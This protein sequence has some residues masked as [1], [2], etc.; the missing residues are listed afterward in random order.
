MDLLLFL[1]W[2]SLLLA[3]T[4]LLWMLSLILARLV[5]E[6]GD[7]QRALDRKAVM[8]AFIEVMGG[9][10]G[11]TARLQPYQWRARLMAEALLELL[12]LVR[13]AERNRVIEALKSLN[14]DDRFRERVSRGS[15]AGRLAATEVLEAFPGDQTRHALNRL[16]RSARDPEL[17]IAAVRALIEIG[18]PPSIDTV[19]RN[20]EHHDQTDSPLYGP[21]LRRLVADAPDAALEAL[22]KTSFTPAACAVLADAVGA[23]GDYR[24]VALLTPRASAP[25]PIVRA[26][27]VRALGML[28]HP[29]AETAIVSAIV[30]PEWEVRSEACEAAGRI[31][32]VRLMPHLVARLADEVWWVRFR[33][34]EALAALGVAGIESLREA[35]RSGDNVVQRMAAMTL[36][37]RGLS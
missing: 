12:A 9:D 5:R 35:S 16:Y 10:G 19:L 11:A 15:R 32:G 4:A 23:S 2:F 14:V 17:R 25:N 33:A 3:G 30:D 6:R 29:A 24:A 21:V 7:A 26:A 28:G 1:W 27:S 37:E 13:G 20:L 22:E 8:A 34:A 31:G 18:A 36:A